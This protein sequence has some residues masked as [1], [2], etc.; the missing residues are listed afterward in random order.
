MF[1]PIALGFLIYSAA[2]PLRQ[3]RATNWWREG[4]AASAAW[5]I[6]WSALGI[7]TSEVGPHA[8]DEPALIGLVG[9]IIF[10]PLML[11]SALLR[12]IRRSQGS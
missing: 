12:M 3:S 2:V 9:F 6:V 8:H 10:A 11:L 5:A 1:W 4:F 7:A